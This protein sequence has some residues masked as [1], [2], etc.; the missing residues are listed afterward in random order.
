MTPF[1]LESPAPSR[2]AAA[3]KAPVPLR[4]R[5]AG[6]FIVAALVVFGGTG[7]VVTALIEGSMQRQLETRTA[8]DAADLRDRLDSA[9]YERFQD[10]KSLSLFDVPSASDRPVSL[11]RAVLSRR[12]RAHAE[13]AWIAYA[14]TAGKVVA[15][16]SPALD[17]T[18]VSQRPWFTAALRGPYLGDVHGSTVLHSLHTRAEAPRVIDFAFPASDDGGR[19]AGVII[20]QVS[21]DS[22]RDLARAIRYEAGSGAEL[23]VV[24]ADG[25]VLLG[26]PELEGKPLDMER[27]KLPTDS[28]GNAAGLDGRSYVAAASLTRGRAE[29]PGFGWTVVAR[30]DHAVAYAPARQAKAIIATAVVLFIAVFILAGFAIARRIAR[31]ME[32]WADVA[33]RIGLGER[34][35]RFPEAGGSAELDRLGAALQSMFVRVSEKEEE[36]QRRVSERTAA[37]V[38]VTNEVEAERERLAYALDASRLAI[39]DMDAETG[40]LHLSGEWGRMMGGPVVAQRIQATELLETVPEEDH[41]VISDAVFSVLKGERE[42]Y[43]VEHRVRRPDGTLLWLRSRG[44]VVQRSAT[45]RALRMSG[46]NAD[47]T[48]RKIV[49]QLL[50]Q[51]ALMDPLTALPNK[52]LLLERLERALAVSRRKGTPVG[53][54]FIDLDGFKGVNDT[55]GHAAG[56]SLLKQVAA[57]FLACV[58]ASDTVAR[59]GGDE[60]VVLLEGCHTIDDVETVAAKLLQALR[61]PFV[62]AE[63]TASISCSVGTVISPRDGTLPDDLLGN[64][65]QAMYRAK[66]NGKNAVARLEAQAA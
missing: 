21:W 35:L 66:R 40:E 49:E 54:L 25:T 13:F 30:Q 63:G 10:V 4:A 34:E 33:D 14:D 48:Q 7:A 59:M 39:W 26:P 9:L 51:Q 57:R 16:T 44:R 2:D 56:D 28:A 31:P 43:D 19:A 20:A 62:L 42:S 22:V 23:L 1:A 38:E 12:Q 37:L 50:A 41:A 3:T 45:G 11:F 52:R 24:A 46:T 61:S 36:L 15:S 55:L 58:R 53:L 17:G 8:R 5:L 18:D 29:F 6:A 27:S 65:D 60:F 64:A 32:A 47:I